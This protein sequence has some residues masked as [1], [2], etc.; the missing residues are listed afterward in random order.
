MQSLEIIQLLTWIIALVEFTVGLYI[1]LL[2]TRN[3]ANQHVSFLLV[4]IA[5][6][7][8][9]Q[10]GLLAAV[11]LAQAQ[12]PS[13]ILAATTP[14]IQPG[15]LLI[16]LVLLKPRLLQGRW[17]SLRWGLYSILALPLILTGLD[18]LFHTNLW[19]SSLTAQ[20]YSGGFVSLI[21]Y[22]QGSWAPNLRIIY[23]YG[24]TILTIFPIA[25]ISFFDKSITPLTRKLGY[26][27]L[28]TQVSAVLI[29][30]AIFSTGTSYFSILITST[31]FALGYA[32]A[33]FWQLISERRLQ[34]GRLQP[35]LTILI[36]SI[37]TPA[38]VAIPTILTNYPISQTAAIIT[39]LTGVVMIGALT[40]L[41]IRQAIQPIQNLTATA[42]AITDGDLTRV[43]TIDSEDEI[44]SLAEAIN[45]MTEQLL[46]L[47]GSLEQRVFERTK[48]LET[49]SHQLQA[50]ADV[51]R[52][53]SSIL[54]V[55]QLIQEVVNV[56]RERFDLYYVGLFLVDEA[57]EWALLRAGTGQAGQ[58]MLARQHRIQVG[59]GMIGWCIAHAQPRVAQEAGEDAVRQVTKELHLTR[60]EAA[61]P[62]RAR[63]QVIGALTVQDTRP[64]VFDSE[65]M[66]VLQ[67]MADLVSIAISN[68]QL[69]SESQEALEATQRAYGGKVRDAWE[70]RLEQV[71]GF[72]SNQQGIS[73]LMDDELQPVGTTSVDTLTIP[74][75]VRDMVVGEILAQRPNDAGDWSNDEISTIT[76]I[77]EQ[78]GVALEGAR[79]YEDIQQQATRERL[80][81]EITSKIRS[82]NDPQEMLQMAVI[83]LRRVLQAHRA[84][85]IVTPPSNDHTIDDDVPEIRPTVE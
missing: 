16:A 29:N 24:I 54:D 70:D 43:A 41:A 85:I 46:E 32:Y 64:D 6:N 44:G 59:Q 5:I 80:V 55:D 73:S 4:L 1:L 33:A 2:N 57:G 27:L 28:I 82:T 23:I 42:M 77:I 31:A 66:S 68:A 22:T 19:F 35:R 60:S 52:A 34:R 18:V 47:I 83:E 51:S 37:S 39:V 56:I 58:E 81:T 3:Q 10:G 11:D 79:L 65:S 50:A 84:Q 20:D 13:M 8:F 78:L 12:V 62:L 26:T 63:G 48:E 69:F 61:V 75:K 9:A 40:S 45:R 71:I 21:A 49:R 17:R 36:L 25:Y 38:L 7:T 30:F 67:T 15:L 14:A 76:R 53:V 72:R 74:I